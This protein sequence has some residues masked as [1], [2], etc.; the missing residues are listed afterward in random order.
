VAQAALNTAEAQRGNI[1]ATRSFKKVLAP[2]DGI[3]IQRNVDPGALVTSGSNTTNTVLFE[4]AQTEILKIYVNIPEQ[5]V[6]Y[7]HLGDKALV[8]VQ[9]YPGKNFVGTVAYIAGGLDIA[10]RTLLTE[11]HVPNPDHKLMPGMYSQVHFQ[12]PAP[13]RLVILPATA[14][15]TRPDGNFVFTVDNQKRVH[16]R[17]IEMGRDLG[18]EFEVS[19]GVKLGDKCVISPS[20]AIQDG[21]LVTPVRAPVADKSGSA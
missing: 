15:Q 8:N 14:L 2:F 19:K 5:Y 11:I 4:V 3:I 12:S 16:M 1:S 17:K 6:P 21:L 10:S 18:G 7:I 13:V 20:S 9:E